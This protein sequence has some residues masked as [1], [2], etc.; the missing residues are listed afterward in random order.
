MQ[1]GAFMIMMIH[2]VKPGETIY[3]IARQYQ[4]L[5]G[6]IERDNQ[7]TDPQQLVTGQTLVIPVSYTHLYKLIPLVEPLEYHL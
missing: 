6:R 5:P 4:V 3:S 7:L 2:R 1:K